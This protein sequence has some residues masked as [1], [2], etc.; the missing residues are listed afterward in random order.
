MDK[1]EKLYNYSFKGIYEM[2]VQ[3]IERKERTKVELNQIIAWLTGYKEDEIENIEKTLSLKDFFEDAPF[4]NPNAN[5]IKGVI[6]GCRVEEIED[7][8]TQKIRWMDK[9][10][11]ELAKG[12]K[13]EKIMR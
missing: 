5:L 3:K 9:I 13:I 2:Y 12:K 10:V 7:D 8:I 6:C 11:D 4:M 1:K